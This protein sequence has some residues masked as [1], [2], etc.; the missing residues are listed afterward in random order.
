MAPHLKTL[1]LLALALATPMLGACSTLIPD[2]TEI[3]ASTATKIFRPI[4]ASAKDTCD[5][6]REI[7]EH[8]SRYDTLSSGKPQA[9]KAACDTSVK[10]TAKN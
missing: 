9:Y 7:A 8:N 2:V 4:R 3:D 5:T 6:Q 1:T 10:V